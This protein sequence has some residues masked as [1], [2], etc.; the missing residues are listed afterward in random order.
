MTDPREAEATSD[1]TTSFDF[2]GEKFTVPLEYADMPLSYLEAAS[3]GKG[4]AVQARELLGPEQ[5]AKVRAMSL[6]GRGL[7]E[8]SD[9]INKAMGTDEGEDKPSST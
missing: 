2:R 5:W 7:D 8:L 9:A 1:G 6:T 4:L 3:D